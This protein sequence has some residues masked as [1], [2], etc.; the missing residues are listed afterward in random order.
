MQV[1]QGQ[2]VTAPHIVLVEATLKQVL[3]QARAGERLQFRRKHV[4]CALLQAC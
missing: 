4:I 1:V 2:A 3:Y